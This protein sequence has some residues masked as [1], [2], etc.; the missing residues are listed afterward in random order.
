[1]YRNL[2]F[3]LALA[4]IPSLAHAD[5]GRFN[6]HFDVGGLVAGPPLVGG[7]A[8]HVGADIVLKKPVALDFVIGAGGIAYH[9]DVLDITAGTWV[10]DVSAGVRLRFLDDDRGNLFLVPRLGL[11]ATGLSLSGGL[12]VTLGYEWKVAP[13][14]QLGPYVRPG[15]AFNTDGVGGY[16][17]VGLAI[18][19]KV[20][21]MP[22]DEDRDGVTDDK[23]QCPGTPLGTE[24]DTRGC[25]ILRREMV[26][27]GITFE[28]DRSDIQPS[29]EPTLSRAAQ[30][31]RDNPRAHVE[32]SGHTDD[33]GSAE[34]NQTLS[35]Q[36]ANAV[37]DWLVA[38]GVS[39]DRLTA[40]GF[41]STHPRVPNS[42]E[43]NRA[44]NRRIEFRR[45]D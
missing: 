33:N 23:D 18:S 29:S 11:F 41:G 42:S 36:R 28:L 4:T 22:K 37:V 20:V 7:G 2:A 17:F 10:L 1:M 21:D 39:R 15:L 8:V 9:D 43:A 34:H 14:V 45:L 31:L 27:T 40:L 24:V 25:A 26:L 38:H 30:A 12:D 16:A 44:R 19:V 5:S 35:E 6:L 32:I 13:R 3:A